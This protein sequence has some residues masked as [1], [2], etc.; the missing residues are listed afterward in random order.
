MFA[1]APLANIDI[2]GGL[3]ASRYLTLNPP[4]IHWTLPPGTT[5]Y[6]IEMDRNITFMSRDEVRSLTVEEEDLLW[7]AL[8][9]SSEF[10]ARF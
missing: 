3:L 6:S 4:A 2:S 10:V 9:A 8:R 5:L 7:T 1:L